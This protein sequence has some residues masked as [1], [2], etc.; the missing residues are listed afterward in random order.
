MGEGR[1][2]QQT[3]VTGKRGSKIKIP[4]DAVAPILV[5]VGEKGARYRFRGAVHKPQAD[6]CVTYGKQNI[7]DEVIEVL[8]GSIEVQFSTS[9]KARRVVA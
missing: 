6:K 8:D 2:Q 1:L 3:E 4:H 7:A 9:G 5:F